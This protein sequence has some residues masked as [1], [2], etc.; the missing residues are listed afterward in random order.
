MTCLAHNSRMQ[1]LAR[2]FDADLTF[3]FGSVVGEVESPFP[4]P[5]SIWR[6]AVAEGH[7]FATASRRAEATAGSASRACAA[8]RDHGVGRLL[9]RYSAAAQRVA[10]LDDIGPAAN[11][12]TRRVKDKSR[13]A[14][15]R[16]PV[17]PAREILGNLMARRVAQSR[18]CYVR[19][20]FAP[21]RFRPTRRISR[22]CSACNSRSCVGAAV[23]TI[24]RG[25]LPPK[26]TVP[27][28]QVERARVT[29]SRIEAT[30]CAMASSISPIKRSVR[31]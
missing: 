7:G 9:R 25:L 3:D 16:R 21:F 5:M 30:S 4:T 19:R 20:E 8:R 13:H 23:A 18:Q 1:Q 15:R 10:R 11:R 29:P 14:E 6:E 24:A 22:S 28:V 31:W 17:R 12:R 27:R 26:K 2:K